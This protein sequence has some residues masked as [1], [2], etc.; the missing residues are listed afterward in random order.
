MRCH[1]NGSEWLIDARRHEFVVQCGGRP[2]DWLE[3]IHVCVGVFQVM[4]GSIS[5]IPFT[6]RTPLL[7]P[8]RWIASSARMGLIPLPLADIAASQ[9]EAAA[10][11]QA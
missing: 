7:S 1:G 10:A 6:P 11:A 2:S 8:T 9:L 5:S 4:D 3:R